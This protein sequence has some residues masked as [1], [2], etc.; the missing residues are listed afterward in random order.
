MSHSTYFRLC[1]LNNV[2]K[3][4]L[5]L[6]IPVKHYPPSFTV[7]VLSV[8]II[9]CVWNSVVAGAACIN[10]NGP[11][12]CNSSQ[13]CAQCLHISHLILALVGVFTQWKWANTTNPH[14][15]P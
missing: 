7:I 6:L 4:L 2:C 12:V 9:Y 13:L 14:T 3:E 10:T 11:I 5:K 1:S 8:M 15:L